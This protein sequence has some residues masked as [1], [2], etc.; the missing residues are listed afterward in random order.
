MHQPILLLLFL[1]LCK[2]HYEEDNFA[3]EQTFDFNDA[4]FKGFQAHTEESDESET[5]STVRPANVNKNHKF[6]KDYV[7]IIKDLLK[8][9]EETNRGNPNIKDL[10]VHCNSFRSCYQCINNIDA[11]CKWC[12]DVGCVKNTSRLCK[13]IKRRNSTVNQ[14]CPYIVHQ[15]SILIP[16]GVKINL[17]IKL[18]APDPVIYNK[19]IKCEIR[20]INKIIH[21]KGVLF[22]DIVYCY[23]TVLDTKMFNNVASGT[24][25]LIWGGVQPYSNQIP[26]EVYKCE[27]LAIDCSSC[28]LLPSEYGCGWCN[29]IKNCVIGA[30]C[31]NF[32]EWHIN[33]IS[34]KPYGKT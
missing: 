17:K 1:Y 4:D 24:F 9:I 15:G 11:K 21:L 18:H 20:L 5:I 33:K 34:C 16:A 19:D 6:S 27:N 7:N 2:G 28:K 3:T 23:P 14:D 22:N 25:K 30:K 32:M 13:G 12:H 31:G 8:S 10:T 26:I 29:K